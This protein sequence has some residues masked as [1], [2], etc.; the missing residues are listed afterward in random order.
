MNVVDE[1]VV[2]SAVIEQHK[3]LVSA[4]DAATHREP[5]TMS[6]HVLS[7][8]RISSARAA[9]HGLAGKRRTVARSVPAIDVLLDHR[10]AA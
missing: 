4:I 8:S 1:A 5:S 7:T 2:R 3:E 10:A 9:T 6:N